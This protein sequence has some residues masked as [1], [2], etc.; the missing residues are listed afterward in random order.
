MFKVIEKKVGQ[1]KSLRFSQDPEKSEI[2]DR[3]LH[4]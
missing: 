1:N 2:W 3:S 4:K